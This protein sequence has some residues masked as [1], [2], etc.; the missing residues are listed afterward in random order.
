M[1]L[2]KGQKVLYIEVHDGLLSNFIFSWKLK[3]WFIVV[4]QNIVN[5]YFYFGRWKEPTSPTWWP[6]PKCRC[7]SCLKVNRGGILGDVSRRTTLPRCEIFSLFLSPFLYILDTSFHR[8]AICHIRL[9]ATWELALKCN[10][11]NQLLDFRTLVKTIK[12]FSAT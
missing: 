1:Y 10:L 3:T 11:K 8:R 5:C 12:S 7:L 6:T 2:D 9:L 4:K